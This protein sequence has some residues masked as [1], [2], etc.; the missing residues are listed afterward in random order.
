MVSLRSYSW[1]VRNEFCAVKTVDKTLLD[2]GTTG[3]P[4]DIISFFTGGVLHERQ[5][6]H[7]EFSI[8]GSLASCK[9]S[10]K[11][12]RHRLFLTPLKQKFFELGI[13]VGDLLFFERDLD[14]SSRFILSVLN[15]NNEAIILPPV[16]QMLGENRGTYTTFR[17]G[18]EFFSEQVRFAYSYRCCLS[19]V[20]DMQPSILI[21]SH[22]KP[23]KLSNGREKADK[24]NGLL[25]APHYD[26][27]FDKGFISFSDAGLLMLSEKVPDNLIQKWGLDRKKL[28]TIYP[29]T[30]AYLGFHREFF[31]F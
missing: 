31:G 9:I 7:L 26:K 16:T 15:Q 3:I 12:R 8:L 19:D 28:S 24:F 5:E 6:Q 29:Q 21:A 23:W 30:L 2:E 18:H 11:Q 22:I 25:L 10:R 4:L 17:V 1:E 27:L 20:D 14:V 13:R